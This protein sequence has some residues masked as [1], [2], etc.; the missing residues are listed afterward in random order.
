MMGSQIARPF[1]PN[2]QEPPPHKKKKS[3]SLCFQSKLDRDPGPANEAADG[4][5]STVGTLIVHNT[6]EEKEEKKRS[7]AKNRCP[8]SNPSILHDY[9]F[10][11]T[12]T[13][14]KP[15]TRD[16]DSQNSFFFFFLGCRKIKF[17]ALTVYLFTLNF[18][19]IP[20]IFG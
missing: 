7:G 1:N 3:V 12:K 15:F 16:R 10:H 9:N 6:T 11:L 2:R 18:F 4:L 5:S 8:W 14:G 20:P 17:V 19:F 13:Q